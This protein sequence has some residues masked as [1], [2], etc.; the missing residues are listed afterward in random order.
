MDARKTLK[1]LHSEW[2]DC[3]R[4]ELGVRRDAL[5]GHFVAGEG[6]RRSIMFIGEGPGRNEEAQGRPFIGKSGMIL[7][8]VLEK[9]GATNCYVTNV[10]CCRSCSPVLD[11]A[12]NPILRSY[13]KGPALPVF[14]DE[15]PL[16]SH[17]D[18]CMPRLYE[19][20]YLVDPI[21]IVT[22]G[23]KAAEALL[24]HSVKIGTIR[25]TETTIEIPG[26]LA[27]AVLT[28]KKGVWVR[29]SGGKLIQPTEQGTVKYLMI[30]TLHSAFVA[31]RLADRGPDS[32]TRLFVKDIRYAVKTYERILYEI[33]GS[34]PTGE[35]DTP[36][37]EINLIEDD[38]EDTY[39]QI[40]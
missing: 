22:I 27:R 23:A 9:L 11:D 28:D 32:A 30:P 7:R 36:D 17:M 19:E 16:P 5:K 33:Y 4:C 24:G 35:S 1:E 39:G 20:I 25:G 26:A 29:K 40:E 13:G 3:T 18:A 14:R 6:D 34:I 12:G 2:E 37:E 10:V 21:L 31:R 15:P 8:Y 38:E